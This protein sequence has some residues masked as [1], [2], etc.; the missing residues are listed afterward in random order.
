MVALVHVDAEH[1]GRAAP[2]HLAGVETGVAPDVEHALAGEVRQGLRETLELKAR[3]IAEIMVGRRRDAV[4]EIDVVE[5]GGELR[6]LGTQTRDAARAH[7]RAAQDTRSLT[8]TTR[9]RSPVQFDGADRRRIDVERQELVEVQT[10]VMRDDAADDVAMG[11]RTHM[12]P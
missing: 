10:E 4:A 1:A 11:L 9:P 5:P 6:H 3:V 12:V 7:T 8:A 2:L